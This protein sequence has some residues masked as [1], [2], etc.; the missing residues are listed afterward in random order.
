MFPTSVLQLVSLPFKLVTYPGVVRKR[1]KD[2][3][4]SEANGFI[5]PVR[6]PIRGQQWVALQAGELGVRLVI[7]IVDGVGEGGIAGSAQRSLGNVLALVGVRLHRI[8]EDVGDG[9]GAASAHSSLGVSGTRDEIG[10]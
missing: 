10:G 8:D 1:E 4:Q 6:Q 9:G 2:V 5:K 3:S 7:E